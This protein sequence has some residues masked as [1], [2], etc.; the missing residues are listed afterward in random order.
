D[1][2]DLYFAGGF[3]TLLHL[4]F[5]FKGTCAGKAGRAFWKVNQTAMRG[6]DRARPNNLPVNAGNAAL[7]P[8]PI[9][10]DQITA[11]SSCLVALVLRRVFYP[12]RKLLQKRMGAR[13]TSPSHHL[14]SKKMKSGGLRDGGFGL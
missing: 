14:L 10:L 9:C 7:E 3:E 13:G 11:L 5:V 1:R 4:P 12:A 8:F 6:K 2:I